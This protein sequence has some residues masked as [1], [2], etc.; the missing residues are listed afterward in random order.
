[1]VTDECGLWYGRRREQGEQNGVAW[2]RD[3]ASVARGPGSRVLL[4][5][6]ERKTFVFLRKG[7]EKKQMLWLEHGFES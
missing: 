3:V 4:H 7:D 5:A 2:T 6:R 1:M